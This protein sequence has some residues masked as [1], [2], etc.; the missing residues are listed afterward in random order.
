MGKTM[1]EKILAKAAGL[2]E[3]SAGDIL[4]VNVDRAM[5]DDI[6]GPRVE[7]AEKMLEIK[8][9]VWDKDKVVVI[10]DH[11]TPPANIKQAQIVKFTRE[12]AASHGIENYYEYVGPCHQAC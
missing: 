9:Q 3:A 10:S 6:L 2:A 4:W 8:D 1:S 12:W 11:Y 5:M 7:I